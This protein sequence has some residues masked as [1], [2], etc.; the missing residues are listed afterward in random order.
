MQNLEH[1]ATVSML[2]GKRKETSTILYILS[3][4]PVLHKKMQPELTDCKKGGTTMYTEYSF[5][6]IV[7]GEPMEFVSEE[8]YLEYINS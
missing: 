1:I 4:P 6:G 8:E 5:I 7:D 2:N 3:V